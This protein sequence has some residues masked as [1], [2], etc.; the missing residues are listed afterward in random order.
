MSWKQTKRD[1]TIER[2]SLNSR[3]SPNSNHGE[4]GLFEKG[5]GQECVETPRANVQ[6]LTLALK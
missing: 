2:K 5:K 4:A 6:A 1:K 3:K